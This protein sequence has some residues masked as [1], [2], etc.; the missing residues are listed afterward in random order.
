MCK[1]Y[2]PGPKGT[3]VSTRGTLRPRSPVNGFDSQER[4]HVST[5]V[6]FAIFRLGVSS[7]QVDGRGAGDPEMGQPLGIWL[8]LSRRAAKNENQCFSFGV[9]VELPRFGKRHRTT[10]GLLLDSI[11]SSR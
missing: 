3:R 2:T 7:S 4:V 6:C 5:G 9:F 11:L 1:H 8:A 10:P